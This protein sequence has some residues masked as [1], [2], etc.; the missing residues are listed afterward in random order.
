M[1]QVR[2]TDYNGRIQK[3]IG[4]SADN[5]YDPIF[6][7]Q[8]GR[9]TFVPTSQPGTPSAGQ[10]T[11]IESRKH[12]RADNNLTPKTPDG[13]ELGS[14][15]LKRIGFFCFPI[16]HSTHTATRPRS[17]VPRPRN[18][19]EFR[20][21]ESQGRPSAMTSDVGDSHLPGSLSGPCG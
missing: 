14:V 3:D 20:L 13:T 8:V 1:F 9:D 4:T 16:K 11:Y 10:M 17:E 2:R 19:D 7:T 15:T 12:I 5:D 18:S 6:G 21:G